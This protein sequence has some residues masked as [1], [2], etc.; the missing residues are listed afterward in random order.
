MATQRFFVP[1][2]QFEDRPCSLCEVGTGLQPG[3]RELHTRCEDQRA[4]IFLL[5]A[6]E[7]SIRRSRL[8]VSGHID[9]L[10]GNLLEKGVDRKGLSKYG[11][12]IAEIKDCR[13]SSL[14][15]QSSLAA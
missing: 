13:C 5:Y 1:G 3:K 9:S 2:D 6:L 11:R 8:G 10:V 7:F 4:R 14:R 12:C 15:T